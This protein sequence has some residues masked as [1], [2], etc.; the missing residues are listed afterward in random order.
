[1]R[2]RD[3]SVK[4]GLD[5]GSSSPGCVLWG[6]ALPDAHAHIFDEM[7]FQR[8]AVREVAEAIREKCLSDWKLGTMP[9][10]FCDPALKIKTGQI[11]EDF[12]Q[13]FAR[14]KVSLTP[15]SN[16]RIVG[17]QRVHE[18]LALDPLT[19]TPWLTIHHR[20]KYLI[21]T[22]PAMLQDDHNPED[23]DT[24]SD[25]HA[26]D[27]LRYLLMGGLRPGSKA[28]IVKHEKPG[29][30]AAFKRFANRHAA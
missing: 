15:V 23:I 22:M 25:D 13:T 16:N 24:E 4:L 26:C 2:A 17:W 5:W 7:K 19:K 14:Y 29:S 28:S 8:L 18:A 27:T 1:M 30:W 11:G 20:C 6:V 12:I 10:I 21:R 9:P 3:L